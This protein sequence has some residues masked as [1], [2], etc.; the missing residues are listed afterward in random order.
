[1]FKNN[2]FLILPFSFG[3]CQ[4]NNHL[5]ADDRKHWTTT[6]QL[7][8]IPANLDLD[9]LLT[10]ENLVTFNLRQLCQHIPT[11]I[12]LYLTPTL[13]EMYIFLTN[14]FMNPRHLCGRTHLHICKRGHITPMSLL[15]IP[16]L[17]FVKRLKKGRNTK[18]KVQVANQPLDKPKIYIIL[19]YSLA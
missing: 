11:C 9:L 18:S 12:P 5:G 15:A 13:L 17:Y 6:N 4:I 1:M 3:D 7:E 8:S 19:C 16:C 10:K 14:F 2:I